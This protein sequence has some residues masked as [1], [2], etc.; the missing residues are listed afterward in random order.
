MGC[1]AVLT[2]VGG[3][4]GGS[5]SSLGAAVTLT[6]TPPNVIA[7]R[8]TTLSWT[9]S[10][11]TMCRR[12]RS[13]ERPKARSRAPADRTHPQPPCVPPRVHRFARRRQGHGFCGARNKSDTLDLEGWPTPPRSQGDAVPHHRRRGDGHLSWDR[14]TAECVQY[15]ENR[16]VREFNA[17][18]VNL[19]EHRFDPNGAP[20]NSAGQ[21]PF[22]KKGDFSTPN[23]AYFAHAA[24]VVNEALKRNIEVFLFPAYLGYQGGD[25]GWYTEIR[26]NGPKKMLA[27]G[28]FVGAYFSRFPNIVWVI[29]GDYGPNAAR[30]EVSALVRGIQQSSPNPLFTVHNGRYQSGVTQYPGA[31]WIDLNTTYSDCVQASKQLADD[32]G[33]A[34]PIPFF[35]IE[36]K[37]ENEGASAACLRSQAYW[38]ILEGGIGSFFGNNPIWSFGQ[39]WQGALDSPGG[40]SM[41]FVSDLFHS[42]A[43]A[44][45]VPDVSHSVLTA[46]YGDLG[47]ASYAPAAR[48]QNGN[49]VIA[50]SPDQRPLTVNMAKVSG[51]QARAWWFDPSPG[52]ATSIGSYPTTG[53]RSFTPPSSGDW[54]LVLDDSGLG[55]AAPGR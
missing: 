34:G 45:L 7:G 44:T 31:S 39:G 17:I 37:Y 42:R 9:S 2:L 50:Y 28:K 4:G 27:Y 1:A 11:V 51:S 41:G 25:E 3:A 22:L 46:G 36:G 15:L 5:A 18:L 52:Q 40:R 49:T 29:G 30:D 24:N 47:T 55:L 35:L 43:W 48:T 20:N 12:V 33:R 6:A 21:G 54:V 16:K 26:D 8:S 38:S 10:D 13:L 14:A 23:P 32:Y 19:I 53:S